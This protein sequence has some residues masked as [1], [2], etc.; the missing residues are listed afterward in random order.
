M[1]PVMS[2]KGFVQRNA[3]AKRV[4]ETFV[5]FVGLATALK[6]AYEWLGSDAPTTSPLLWAYTVAFFILVFFWTINYCFYAQCLMQDE[7][8]RI[9]DIKRKYEELTL[10]KRISS[11]RNR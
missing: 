1:L 3:N 6:E 2:L 8:D 4:I 7:I 10:S 11:R 9:S 5:A